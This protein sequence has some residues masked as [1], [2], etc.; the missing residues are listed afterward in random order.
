MKSPV[1]VFALNL[2]INFRDSIVF[3]FV[4][5]VLGVNAQLPAILHPDV[6]DPMTPYTTLN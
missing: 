5:F 1:E 6:G 2:Q 3:C 4:C